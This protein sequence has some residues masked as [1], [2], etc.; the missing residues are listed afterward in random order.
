[1]ALSLIMGLAL[2]DPVSVYQTP[3]HAKGAIAATLTRPENS[4]EFAGLKMPLRAMRNGFFMK[5]MGL[6][7]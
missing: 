2:K 4:R 1:M 6:K 5:T 3:S 7:V